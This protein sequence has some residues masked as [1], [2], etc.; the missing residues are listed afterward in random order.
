MLLAGPGH[1]ERHR[2]VS[3][4]PTAR[5]R[6]TAAL[7]AAAVLAVLTLTACGG[8]GANAGSGGGAQVPATPAPG[9]TAGGGTPADQQLKDMRQKLDAAESAVSAA[10]S[11]AAQNN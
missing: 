11:D 7:A 10:D 3:R 2:P 9:A 4:P 5:A 8:S 1:P 6:R